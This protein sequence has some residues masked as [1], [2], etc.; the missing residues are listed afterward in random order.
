MLAEVLGQMT[1][2]K[3]RHNRDSVR[4]ILLY[5]LENYKKL[6]TLEMLAKQL[7]LST[8]HFSHVF[9][10]RVESGCRRLD[11]GRNVTEVAYGAGFSSIRSFNRNFERAMG[12]SPS[13]YKKA[14]NAAKA[15]EKPAIEGSEQKSEKT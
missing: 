9:T 7:H 4:E 14:Q 13:R 12:V 8:Y 10:L 3:R 6:L 11:K 1:L 2:L 15:A 5:C